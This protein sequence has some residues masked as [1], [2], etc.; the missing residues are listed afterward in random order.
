MLGF[1]DLWRF[2]S[3]L[4]RSARQHQMAEVSAMKRSI[5]WQR[6][7]RKLLQIALAL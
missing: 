7:E 3:I 6:K 5:I 1:R 4:A 2:F